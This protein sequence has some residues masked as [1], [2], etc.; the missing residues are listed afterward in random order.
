MSSQLLPRNDLRLLIIADNLLARAGLT[1]L[2]SERGWTV[3]AQS[4]GGG[5]IADVERLQPDILVIDLSWQAGELTEA[6]ASLEGAAPV[7]ALVGEDETEETLES[8]RRV[9]SLS[10]SFALL[11]RES[12]LD[13]ICAALNALDHGLVVL[14]PGYSALPIVAAQPPSAAQATPLTAREDEVLQLL[15]QGLTNRAIALKLGITEHTVK[16]HV[17]AI[18]TKLHAQS[19]TEA[20]VRATQLGMIVL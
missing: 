7:L 5:L 1:A 2:L 9:L 12:D 13:A 10:S 16:F 18:M 19:R 3:S 11:P 17:N 15:A 6:L 20:V 14:D 8:L 4:A